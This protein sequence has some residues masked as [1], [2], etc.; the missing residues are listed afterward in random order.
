M[1]ET[2][3]SRGGALGILRARACGVV[4]VL[5]AALLLQ[6]AVP[7]PSPASSSGFEQTSSAD[8]IVICSEGG[9]HY[10]HWDGSPTDAPQHNGQGN[11]GDCCTL[12]CHLHSAM[13]PV[14]L[15]LNPVSVWV[16]QRVDVETVS[17]P[18]TAPRLSFEARGP[19]FLA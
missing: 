5:L 16:E 13:L 11:S 7:L 9:V 4:R 19:P 18:D 12:S 3:V 2:A 8:R 14:S 10:I 1:T 17:P 6:F 15:A